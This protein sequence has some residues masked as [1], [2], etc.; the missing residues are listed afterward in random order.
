[1]AER[2]QISEEMASPK[3]RS[4]RLL[5]FWDF[6]VALW[7]RVDEIKVGFGFFGLIFVYIL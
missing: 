1:M 4:F 6:D 3:S 2:Y 7:T 5:H